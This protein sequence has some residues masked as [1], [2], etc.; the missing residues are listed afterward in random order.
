[1]SIDPLRHADLI[2]FGDIAVDVPVN[3]DRL[4][5]RDDKIWAK[6]VGE[7]P[8]GMGANAASA[9]AALGGRAAL[10]ARVGRDRRGEIC[11]ADLRARGVDV[12][13]V[14][15]VDAETFWSLALVDP[16]GEKSLIQF[17]SD[18]F[19]VPWGEH[20]VTL[21]DYARACHTVAEGSPGLLETLRY[22][23]SRSLQTSLD[24]EPAD[25]AISAVKE[26]L[27]LTDILFCGIE[28]AQSV[29][30]TASEDRLVDGLLD[31]GPDIV[32]LTLGGNGCIAAARGGQRIR[33]AG[34]AVDVVDTTGAGDCFAGAFLFGT[35]QGWPLRAT[36][37]MANLMAAMSVTAYGS[38]GRLLSLVE[39]AELPEAAGLTPRDWAVTGSPPS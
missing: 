4:P 17:E 27:S 25:M 30:G 15:S 23:R 35:L 13:S 6:T 36:A 2:V 11:L 18:A 39:L 8:G 7:Y 19:P 1:V 16:S 14:V 34:Q 20:N 29:V 3:L 28:A 9:F 21:L 32:A 26:L 5:R 22:C 31:L 33:V 12:Q 37:E 24:L 38:R 10:V